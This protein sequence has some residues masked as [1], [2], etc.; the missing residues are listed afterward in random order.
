MNKGSIFRFSTV[1]GCSEDRLELGELVIEIIEVLGTL[2]LIDNTCESLVDRPISNN[3]SGLNSNRPGL[4]FSSC[5][6]RFAG[7]VVPSGSDN[8][9]F[10]KRDGQGPW[11]MF[12]RSIVLYS[13]RPICFGGMDLMIMR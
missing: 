3:S 9:A 4:N 11:M 7:T 10:P 2:Y 8:A 6:N 5:M 12:F 1:G 13:C